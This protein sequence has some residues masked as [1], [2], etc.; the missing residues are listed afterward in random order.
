MFALQSWGTN[1]DHIVWFLRQVHLLQPVP[2]TFWLNWGERKLRRNLFG[3]RMICRNWRNNLCKKCACVCLRVCTCLWIGICVWRRRN[4][5]TYNTIRQL[6]EWFLSPAV[7]KQL[8]KPFF[9]FT[10]HPLKHLQHCRNASQSKY[11]K[12]F[13]T[14][15]TS[16][17]MFLV[18]IK[19]RQWYQAEVLFWNRH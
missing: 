1:F 11:F 16:G 15:V 10:Y 7:N 18:L 5:H 2:R 17:K 3:G 13:Y 19:D 4:T 14:S 6:F 9:F 12:F 8:R